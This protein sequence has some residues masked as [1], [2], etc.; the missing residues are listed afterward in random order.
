MD[1]AEFKSTVVLPYVEG[2]SE[3]LRCCL[4]QQGI[5][6]V[7]K[8]D[9]T[10]RWHLVQPKDAVNP[11]KQDGVLY[12]IPYEC[13]KVY[14]GETGRSMQERIKEH[15]RDIQLAGTQTS[16]VSE[17]AHDTGH[18]PIWNEVKFID[19]DPHW[20]TR[21]IKEAIHIRLHPNNINRDSGI[22]ILKHGCPRSK[23]TTTGERYNSGPLREQ[24][25]TRTME[26]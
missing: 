2:V 15:D 1:T 11:A 14:I 21:R 24:L 13:G 23:Y 8:S 5:R 4:E 7:F 26:Q 10:L 9:T 6:T 19:W 22:E 25:L 17:H 20:Y 12:R 16:A 18:Y 3:S